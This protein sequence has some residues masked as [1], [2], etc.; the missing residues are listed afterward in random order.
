MKKLKYDLTVET[1]ALLCPNPQE[2]YAKAYITPMVANN[3]RTLPGIKTATKLANVLF[4]NILQEANC[5]FSATD[6]TLDAIDINVCPLSAMAQLCQFDLEQSFVSLQ[7]SQGSNGA[8]DVASFMSYY[9][10]QMASKIGEEIE[11][12]RWNGDTDSLDTTLALCD[13]H[14]KR[15]TA[16][17]DVVKV[18]GTVSTVNNVIAEM[19]KLIAGLPNVL[20]GRRSDLRIYASSNIVQNYLI[21]TAQGNNIAFVTEA[22]TLKFIGIEIVECAGLPTNTMVCA[23]KNDLIY[24]F[25][26]EGDYNDLRAVNLRDT[27]AEP[28]IRT[29]TDLKLGFYHTNPTQ[30]VLYSPLVS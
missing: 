21:A 15:L 28:V 30:I 24:A 19:T 2:F 22:L 8:W 1:N 20:K 17:S 26:G 16:D 5:S 29:R 23:L 10:E 27:V 6:S 7:M 3:F 25:D 12:I 13:G 4:D 18:H 14:L 9:W 11:L